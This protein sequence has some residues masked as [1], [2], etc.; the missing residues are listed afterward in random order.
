MLN[1]G[2]V[3][4]LISIISLSC[5]LPSKPF[6]VAQGDDLITH[7]CKIT[8]DFVFCNDTIYS[9]TRA[10]YARTNR[11][12]L[13]Y[14]AIQK[15]LNNTIDTKDVYLPSEIKSIEAGGGDP[16]ILQGL[17]N[18]FG[19]YD[20]VNRRL[21]D[22]LDELDS[23]MNYDFDKLSLEIESQVRACEKGFNGRSP[24]TKRN[25]NLIKLANI[26]YAVALLYK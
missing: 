12:I 17:K 26:C 25:D 6:S 7:V 9:D 22:M 4:L 14:I 3:P 23:V 11:L 24:M 16:N 19:N 18:C 5:F 10:I 15:T 20:G 2:F 21:A 1:F 13:S 8:N